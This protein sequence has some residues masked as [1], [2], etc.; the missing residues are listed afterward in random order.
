METDS[1]LLRMV[2][3]RL[4]NG[5]ATFGSHI[6]YTRCGRKRGQYPRWKAEKSCQAIIKTKAERAF[7]MKESMCERFDPYFQVRTIDRDC[8]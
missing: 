6:L 1:K 8:A 7:V 5:S 3:Q 4:D 2:F